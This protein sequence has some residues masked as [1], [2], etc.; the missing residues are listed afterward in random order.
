MIYTFSE[1]E[2]SVLAKL[3]IP[4]DPLGDLSDDQEARLL[5]ILSEHYGSVAYESEGDVIG[6]ILTHMAQQAG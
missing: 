4:F 3:H 6:D 2:K 1:K 5:D